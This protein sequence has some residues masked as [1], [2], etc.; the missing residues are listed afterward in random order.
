VRYLVDGYNLFFRV[1]RETSPFQKELERFIKDLDYEIGLL[2]L[3]VVLVLDSCRD[4]AEVFPSS[5]KLEALKVLFSPKELCADSYILELLSWE[6]HLT[7][8]VTSD[9]DL[10]LKARRIGVQTQSSEEFAL[11]LSKKTW[12]NGRRRDR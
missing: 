8:L 5:K 3:E 6:S 1:W 2:G 9:K 11:F 7:T 4:R 10:A 12:K